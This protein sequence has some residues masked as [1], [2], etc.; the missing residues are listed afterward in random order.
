M[1]FV[2]VDIDFFHIYLLLEPIILYSILASF[3]R[4]L[5]YFGGGVV[6]VVAML[7]WWKSQPFRALR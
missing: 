7:F 1:Q 3:T 4:M 5:C 2:K 6:V